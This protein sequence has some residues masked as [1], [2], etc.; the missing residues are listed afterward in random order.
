MSRHPLVN[1]WIYLGFSISLLVS[2]TG[3]GWM[4]HGFLFSFLLFLQPNMGSALLRRLKPFIFFFPVMLVFYVGFS[5][6]LTNNS[7]GMIVNEAGFGFLKLMLMVAAMAL[8]FETTPIQ[9]ILIV[10]RS[11]WVKMNLPWRRVE[12]FFVF[13]EMTLRFYPTFQDNWKDL[14]QARAALELEDGSTKWERIRL[15]TRGMPGLLLYNLRRADDV[16]AAMR[17]RGYGL[18]FPRGVTR[19]IPFTRIHC[20]QIFLITVAYW[21]GHRFVPL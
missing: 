5:L 18:R 15:A 1:L 20:W 9:N 12:D 2:H 10:I 16:A 6:W 3:T 4:I 17:L 19:P 21:L 13:L 8:F 7:L 11:V 14:R